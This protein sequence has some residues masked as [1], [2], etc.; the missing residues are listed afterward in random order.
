MEAIAKGACFW[1][2]GFCYLSLDLFSPTHITVV[3]AKEVMLC[4]GFC[5]AREI[6][7]LQIS[8]VSDSEYEPMNLP[9]FTILSILIA[10]TSSHAWGY[11]VFDEY[12]VLVSMIVMAFLSYAHMV[13]FCCKE[14]T[15]ELQIPVFAMPSIFYIEKKS[16][17]TI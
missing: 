14:I 8:H 11:P 15:K 16:K 10:N 13:Y 17:E 4:F 7:Y 3:A 6:G 2:F 12:Y 9:N 1:Y 5:F